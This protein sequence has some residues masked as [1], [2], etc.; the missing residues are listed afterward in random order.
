MIVLNVVQVSFFP[1]WDVEARRN[2]FELNTAA[3][4][5]PSIKQAVL[6]SCSPVSPYTNG[7]F[8]SCL[9][10]FTSQWAQWLKMCWG[11]LQRERGTKQAQE[12]SNEAISFSAK[13]QH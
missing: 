11:V 13:S 12:K 8:S 2:L 5:I 9:R 7:D 6:F 4:M 3:Q 1:V 10:F